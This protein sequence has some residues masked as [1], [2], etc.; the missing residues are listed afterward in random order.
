MYMWGGSELYQHMYPAY[1]M[2]RVK[3]LQCLQ[4][5]PDTL[6]TKLRIKINDRF[7]QYVEAVLLHSCTCFCTPV[8]YTI[9]N[10]KYFLDGPFSYIVHVGM[11]MHLGCARL[12]WT[13]S[14]KVRTTRLRIGQN[15]RA[16]CI[17]KSGLNSSGHS[18]MYMHTARDALLND[19]RES[20]VRFKRP[21][22]QA[23]SVLYHTCQ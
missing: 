3:W 10:K 8:C 18:Y 5:C 17:K 4:C 16:V 19:W 14:A 1:F 21:A 13:R 23:R 15:C 12:L 20:A 9:Y 22:K 6:N 2:Y 7:A 11:D